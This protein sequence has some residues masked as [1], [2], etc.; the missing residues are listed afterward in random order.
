MIRPLVPN[1]SQAA[2]PAGA[3]GLTCALL[4]GIYECFGDLG[5]PTQPDLSSARCS[6]S[7]SWSQAASR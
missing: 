6:R 7:A 3:L 4:A 5:L 2:L 1:W